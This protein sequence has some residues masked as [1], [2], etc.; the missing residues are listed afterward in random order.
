[1][2]NKENL[3]KRWSLL[4]RL[5]GHKSPKVREWMGKAKMCALKGNFGPAIE[6]LEMA[7]DV[8]AGCKRPSGW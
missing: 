5:E 1:M 8:F 2:S 7:M 6:C 3:I 4:I